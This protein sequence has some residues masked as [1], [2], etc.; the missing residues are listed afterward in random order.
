MTNDF[1]I[2][3]INEI[4]TLK[5][6]GKGVEGVVDLVKFKKYNL[7]F[8]RK[9]NTAIIKSKEIIKNKALY[10]ALPLNNRP[11]YIEIIASEKI[12]KILLNK[13]CPHF[14]LNF[15]TVL[16]KDKDEIYFFNEY[17]NSETLRTFLKSISPKNFSQELIFNIFFQI[18]SAL[19]TMDYQYNMIHS[20]L[21]F[22]NILISK[23][24][25]NS[26]SHWKYKINNK[27]YYLPNLGYQIFINDYGNVYI[28]NKLESIFFKNV[29]FK[30][31]KN[32]GKYKLYDFYLI[33]LDFVKYFGNHF[34]NFFNKYFDFPKNFFD[35][36]K[37]SQL[38]TFPQNLEIKDFIE[39]IYTKKDISDCKNFRWYCYNQ[40]IENSIELEYYNLDRKL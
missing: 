28:P 4:E 37:D 26:K 22:N 3:K 25:K 33:K 16:D 18:L 21:H 31:I 2:L 14:I 29:F 6:L 30:N 38:D 27:Y 10:E 39:F 24:P 34:T 15:K 36:F 23:V 19:Y 8:V 32:T 40:K 5:E 17:L 35:Y 20:D 7:K 1:K 9:Y 13:I 12:N 11:G